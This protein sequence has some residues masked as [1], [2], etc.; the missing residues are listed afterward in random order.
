M[1]AIDYEKEEGWESIRDDKKKILYIKTRER[2]AKKRLVG[3]K[4]IWMRDDVKDVLLREH[5]HI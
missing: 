5:C 1:N 3:C 2:N 4:V